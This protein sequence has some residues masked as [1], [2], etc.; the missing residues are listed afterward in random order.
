MS[1]KKAL[2]IW[3]HRPIWHR[4]RPSANRYGKIFPT[5]RI[6]GEEDASLPA[7]ENTR[8]RESEFRWIIDPLDGTV[9]FVHGVPH[10]AVSIALERNG[11][12]LVG[13]VFDPLQNECFTAAAGQGAESQRP[14]HTYQQSQC[15]V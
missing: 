15:I 6:I 8:L 1:A 5:H 9:N 2:P 7:D 14:I 10:Y 12:L 3:L 4:N 11:E 13:A